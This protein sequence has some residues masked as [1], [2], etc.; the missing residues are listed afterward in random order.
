MVD[1]REVKLRVAELDRAADDKAD[2]RVNGQKRS[3]EHQRHP[4]KVRN[5]D[6]KIV[7]LHIVSNGAANR[8]AAAGRCRTSN[9]AAEQQS[10]KPRSD[11][12]AP[13]PGKRLPRKRAKILCV[14]KNPSFLLFGISNFSSKIHY[15]EY[16][17]LLQAMKRGADKLRKN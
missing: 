2:D 5:V 14:H 6:R 1:E 13:A 11:C 10:D 3:E 16:D 9:R 7:F 4:D 12:N 8:A 15:R 17:R